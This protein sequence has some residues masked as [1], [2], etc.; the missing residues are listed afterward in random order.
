MRTPPRARL[1]PVREYALSGQLPQRV[2][3]GTLAR[4]AACKQ[5]PTTS[6]TGV[7]FLPFRCAHPLSGQHIVQGGLGRARH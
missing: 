1:F 7:L 3:P 4:E 2:A 5:L 6:K